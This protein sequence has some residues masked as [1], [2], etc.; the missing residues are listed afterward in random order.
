MMCWLSSLANERTCKSRAAE[1]EVSGIVRSRCRTFLIVSSSHEFP[2]GARV[3]FRFEQQPGAA[4]VEDC[5]AQG[6]R[7]LVWLELGGG[8]VPPAGPYAA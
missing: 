6:D 7:F 4:T 8:L 1:V 3:N 2:A 5:T